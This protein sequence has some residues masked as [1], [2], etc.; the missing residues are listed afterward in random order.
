M[1]RIFYDP[2]PERELYHFGIKGMKWYQRRYQNEDGSLTT[3]GRARYATKKAK[4]EDKADKYEARASKYAAKAAK[5]EKG[6][7]GRKF[8]LESR[9][10]YNERTITKQGKAS[11]YKYKAAENERKARD[12]R[13]KI[14]DIDAEL[15]LQYDG[16]NIPKARMTDS[17]DTYKARVRESSDY[18]ENLKG[19]DVRDKK[20]IKEGKTKLKGMLGDNTRAEMKRV[21][22]AYKEDIKRERKAALSADKSR[23]KERGTSP[24]VETFIASKK[25]S[26]AV[27]RANKVPDP[28]EVYKAN[29]EIGRLY[30]MSQK[31]RP[32]DWQ[33]RLNKAK[34][35]TSSYTNTRIAAEQSFRQSLKKMG[36]SD[37]EREMAL[38]EYRRR[39]KV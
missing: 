18:Q 27:E 26:D 14:A 3:A 34:S 16:K 11:A 21:V 37:R 19:V 39:L 15:K 4:L 33:E 32:A 38:S 20:S 1:T 30:N 12:A 8:L 10:H 23:S 5:K 7:V 17:N 28:K 24:K 13:G 2:R 31:N 29:N 25:F 36:L 9:E 22:K 35:I 6:L